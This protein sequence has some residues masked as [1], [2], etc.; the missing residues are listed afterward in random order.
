MAE[1]MLPII[2]PPMTE[3]VE[4]GEAEGVS[5]ETLED[6]GE[7]LLSLTVPDPG[8]CVEAE[9]EGEGEAEGRT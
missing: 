6:V 7:S 1:V 4:E 3:G 9:G 5:F 2:P 8:D